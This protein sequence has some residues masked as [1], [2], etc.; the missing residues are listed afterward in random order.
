MASGRGKSES[1]GEGVGEGGEGLMWNPEEGWDDDTDPTGIVL[2]YITREEVS[3]RA[4]SSSLLPVH[5]TFLVLPSV[6]YLN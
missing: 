5:F 6:M 2:D 1:R 3:R 4:F